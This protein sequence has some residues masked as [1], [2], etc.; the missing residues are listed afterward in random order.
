MRYDQVDVL[1][2][3]PGLLQQPRI[4]VLDQADSPGF[5]ALDTMNLWID[6]ARDD[7]GVVLGGVDALFVNDEEAGRMMLMDMTAGEDL[8]DP[9]ADY[10]F[11][12]AFSSTAHF[13]GADGVYPAQEFDRVAVADQNSSRVQVFLLSEIYEALGIN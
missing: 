8:F 10:A 5:V 9:A 2:L 4:Q 3:Q 13:A 11:R 12:G 7:L 6:V 1:G